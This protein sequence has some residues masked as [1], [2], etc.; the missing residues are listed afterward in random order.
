[1]FAERMRN[2]GFVHHVRV[3]VGEV[4]HDDFSGVDQIKNILKYRTVVPDVIL[5]AGLLKLVPAKRVRC[6]HG[7]KSTKRSPTTTL[8]TLQFLYV[9]TLN[10]L[11][12]KLSKNLVGKSDLKLTDATTRES[13]WTAYS[14]DFPSC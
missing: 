7:N 1:M 11:L 10:Q 4:R 9:S 6:L 5:Q 13:Y 3:L 14:I 8:A 12:R 2:P